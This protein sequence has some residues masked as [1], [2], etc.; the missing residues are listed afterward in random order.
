[1]MSFFKLLLQW[2]YSGSLYSGLIDVQTMMSCTINSNSHFLVHTMRVQSPCVPDAHSA[3][4]PHYYSLIF[5]DFF[6]I[7]IFWLKYCSAGFDQSTAIHNSYINSK[8][9][10]L[11]IICVCVYVCMC[12]HMSTC[13]MDWVSPMF[14]SMFTT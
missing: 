10:N 9:V 11:S 3:L 6:D 8:I 4:Q 13:I 12:A 1:M 14:L 2:M 5:I 7:E